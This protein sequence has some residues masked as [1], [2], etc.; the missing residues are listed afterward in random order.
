MHTTTNADKYFS[1]Y[2]TDCWTQIANHSPVNAMIQLRAVNHASQNLIDGLPLWNVICQR[3][4]FPQDLKQ[5]EPFFR[6]KKIYK[7]FISPLTFKTKEVLSL[8]ERAL[9]YQNCVLEE[10]S[11]ELEQVE[12]FLSKNHNNQQEIESCF[13]F[14]KQLLLM[15]RLELLEG[16]EEFILKNSTFATVKNLPKE[17][18][19]FSSLKSIIIDHSSIKQIGDLSGLIHLEVLKIRSEKLEFINF[20]SLPSLTKL[21]L[22][23]SSIRSISF[24]PGKNEAPNLKYLNLCDCKKIRT[25]L[26]AHLLPNLIQINLNQA[27]KFNVLDLTKFVNLRHALVNKFNANFIAH[28]IQLQ[29][30]I[31]LSESDSDN[32]GLLKGD[33]I[34][35]HLDIRRRKPL[36]DSLQSTFSENQDV[37]E[38]AKKFFLD[39]VK[40][41]DAIR[42]KA[43]ETRKRKAAERAEDR[44]RLRAIEQSNEKPAPFTAT[45]IAETGSPVASMLAYDHSDQSPYF[46]PMQNRVTN[47]FDGHGYL[48]SSPTYNNAQYPADDYPM[49]PVVYNIYQPNNR[50]NDGDMNFAHQTNVH[51]GQQPMLHYQN[52]ETVNNYTNESHYS[53]DNNNAYLDQHSMEHQQNIIYIDGNTIASQEPKEEKQPILEEKNDDDFE[54]GEET[55]EKQVLSKYSAYEIW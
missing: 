42:K 10:A 26:G 43:S 50:F 24:Y 7:L 49:E 48:A 33:F 9:A 40:I 55:N 21:D 13:I 37:H 12:S 31:I 25:I 8:E 2:H 4:D 15:N 5:T 17:I 16:M 54:D 53:N 14:K 44:K 38:T 46:D 52:S 30:S 45:G 32:I 19:R 6:A 11:S 41:K 36:Y 18:N 51:N 20:N 35:C 22:G 27:S 1:V 28:Y 3:V 29:Q 47:Q 34:L 39:E 23:R